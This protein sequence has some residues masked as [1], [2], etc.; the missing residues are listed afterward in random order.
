MANQTDFNVMTDDDLYLFNEG[1]HY[2]LYD[3]LGAHL[4]TRGGHQ[5]TYF[6]VWA[7]NAEYVS[8]IGNFN[9]WNKASHALAPRGQSGVW[10][11]YFPEARRGTLY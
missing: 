10:E 9:E 3:K 5:G 1:K 2:R 4:L 11:G 7:P 6:A 8:V